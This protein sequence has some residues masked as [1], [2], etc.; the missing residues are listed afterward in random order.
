LIERA[1]ERFGTLP[2]NSSEASLLCAQLGERGAPGVLI[3]QL[4]AR[5]SGSQA[6]SAIDFGD[7]QTDHRQAVCATNVRGYL[8]ANLALAT[9]D[10]L[11]SR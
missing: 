8:F 4:G 3:E 6:E 9:D 11:V 7:A 1:T 2:V 10:V 5:E